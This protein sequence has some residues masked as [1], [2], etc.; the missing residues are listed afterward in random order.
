MERK[1]L[2]AQKRR[3]LSMLLKGIKEIWNAQIL[4]PSVNLI[5]CCALI[6]AVAKVIVSEANANANQD[7][8]GQT[9]QSKNT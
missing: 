4:N 5:I 6:I 3:K 7:P 9:A 1:L 2:S 8:R